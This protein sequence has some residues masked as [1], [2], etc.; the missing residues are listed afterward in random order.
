[1]LQLLALLE[2]PEA[3]PAG[4]A[5]RLAGE[6]L[7]LSQAGSAERRCETVIPPASTETL[8]TG[9]G[10]DHAEQSARPGV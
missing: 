5:L 2:H 3:L 10:D 4:A 7:A 6:I 8:L 1:M 9:D